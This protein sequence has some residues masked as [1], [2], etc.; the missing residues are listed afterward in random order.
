MVKNSAGNS[1]SAHAFHERRPP[2]PA[3]PAGYAWLINQYELGVPLP[4]RLAGI[5][6]THHRVDTS[7]WLLLTPRHAPDDTLADHLTFALKWEGVDLSVLAALT[8]AVPADEL[9]AAIRTAPNSRYLRRAW[10]LIEWLLDKSLDVPDADPKRAIEPVLEPTQQFALG[11]GEV[12]ARHRVR[13]TLPGTRDFCPLV[14]ITPAIARARALELDAQARDVIGRT[15]PDV[16]ARAAAFLQLSDSKASFAIEKE[17]PSPDRARRW[18]AAIAR[19]GSE[20]VTQRGLEALQRVVIGDARFVHLGLRT[21]GGFIGEHDRDQREPLPEHISARADDLHSLLRGIEAF[22]TRIRQHG[23]DAVA[24][25]AAMAFGFVY[26]H[27]FEDGNGRIHRW[28]IHHVLA[29]A[30]YTPPNVVFPVSAAML[31]ELERYRHVLESYSRP[32]LPHIEWRATPKGNV[33]VLNDTGPFYRYFDATTHAEFLYHCVEET[34]THDLPAEVAYLEAYDR[35]VADV[36]R[37]VDMP[38]HTVELLHRFLR[39]NGGELSERARGK[40]F[41]ALTVQEVRAIEEAYAT[42]VQTMKPAPDAP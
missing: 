26:I 33:E 32:L 41:R 5:A 4:P 21:E 29:A 1:R 40:E 42:A 28:L 30:R 2:K 9:A 6:T 16:I 15:H 34:V 23:F 22:D 13:N 11:D 25:A 39:Q 10:F 14:R 7:D 36:Q 20:P 27:P 17:R 24:A 19:A 37:I 31:R 3:H 12:S 35:F 18:A 8:R 38:A